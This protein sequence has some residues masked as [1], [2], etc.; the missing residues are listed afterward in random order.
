MTLALPKTGLRLAPQ[1]GELCV[2]DISVSPSVNET[3][4]AGPAPD[5]SRST[6]ARVPVPSRS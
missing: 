2:A 5:F 6:L 3:L 4:G 1:V